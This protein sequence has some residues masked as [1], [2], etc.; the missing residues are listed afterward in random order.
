APVAPELYGKYRS[1]D[2]LARVI[3]DVESLQ[4]FLL[5]VFYPPVVLLLVFSGTI[6]FTLYFSIETAILLAI[7][8]LLTTVAVPAYFAWR[9]QRMDWRTR[10]SR[11]ALSAE[12]AEFLYG[13]RDLK[14]YR[15]L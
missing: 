3:G 13:F 14:L 5:R 8:Y 12:A 4:N 15:K 11:G 6:L 10:E 2:I 1:G 9:K 7:G